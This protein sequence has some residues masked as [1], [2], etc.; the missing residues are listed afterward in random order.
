[1]RA[2]LRAIVVSSLCEHIAVCAVYLMP[3]EFLDG[4]VKNKWQHVGIG[5]EKLS[6]HYGLLSKL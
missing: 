6:T 3:F 5:R 1:M 4:G 2:V